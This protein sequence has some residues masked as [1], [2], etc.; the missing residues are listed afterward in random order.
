M[1]NR[2]LFLLELFISM[3]LIGIGIYL[4]GKTFY[5]C[6]NNLYLN[7]TDA[8]PIYTK[9]KYAAECL[10]NMQWPSWFPNWY[11]GTSVSQYY[12][13]L[14][15]IILTPF[16]FFLQNTTLSLKIY[17]F[18]GL[19]IGGMGVW[20]VFHRYFGRFFGILAGILYVT[21]PYFTISFLF[22][23]TIAQVPIIAIAPWYVICCMEY[24]K[25]PKCKTWAAIITLTFIMLLSH[26]MHGFMIAICVF[27]TMLILSV[28]QKKRI[29]NI[30]MWGIGTGLSA[31]ILGFWWV[32]GVLPLENPGVPFLAADAAKD[33]T[34]NLTWF[35]PK[36][37][38]LITSIFPN[39]SNNIDAY[40]P[41]SIILF[42]IVSFIFIKNEKGQRKYILYFL[43]IHT[44]F[45]FIFAFGSY[46]PFYKFIPLANQLVPGRI[47]TQSSIGA[48]VLTAYFISELIRMVFKRTKSQIHIKIFKKAVSLFMLMF[49]ITVTWHSYLYYPKNVVTDYSFEESLYSQ[50]DNETSNFEKGR[51]AWFGDNFNSTNAYFAYMSNYNMVSG[52][53]IEGT[54]TA[55]YLRYQNTALAYEKGDF[56]LKNIYDMNVQ[57]CFVNV[58]N[59]PWLYDLLE[60][61]GFENI[62][63]VESIAI[64]KRKNNSYFM[65]QIRDSIVIGKASNVFLSDNPW[66]V[67]GYSNNPTEYE[68]D[69]LN[70][71]NVVYYCEPEIDN[72][73]QIHMFEE[74]ISQLAESGKSI[75]VEFGRTIFPAPILGVS[76]YSFKLDGEYTIESNDKFNGK[77]FYVNLDGGFIVQLFGIDDALY[78]LKRNKGDFSFDF[79]GTKNIG[80]GKVYFV[81]GPQ[82]QLKGFAFNYLT[83]KTGDNDSLQQRDDL[84]NGIT[85]K[86]FDPLNMYKNLDL[87][88]FNAHEIKWGANN[89]D[90]NYQSDSD[91]RIMS[92][93]TYTPR[94][95]IYIDGMKTKVDR[96]ENMLT[97]NAPAG[98]HHVSM[99]YTMTNFGIIGI[100]VSMLSLIILVVL[101]ILYKKVL[102]LLHSLTKAN[103]I[104]LEFYKPDIEKQV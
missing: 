53:N 102:L 100:L 36:S 16:E 45:A 99:I 76:P 58:S 7:T 65:E 70:N 74:Q 37:E 77:E 41:I 21:L 87:P 48:I 85:Q 61:N 1:K 4:T 55:D 93:I 42:A 62:G 34:A 56:I 2:I 90:F 29:V 44:I 64:M 50:L 40:F 24:Y 71:Y 91:K 66:F 17:I 47:L 78:K 83:G 89:C 92:S 51:L 60:N 43:Y 86:L 103:S 35:F 82:S 95:K 8:M 57:T 26:V 59:F 75:F 88:K 3:L 12:P 104:Y 25:V 27:F 68:I 23:G 63:V 80:N 33:V 69:Y 5:M 15:Y 49:T 94:W 18:F 73:T 30:L 96:V 97:F 39:M 101:L 6:D 31:G 20:S 11:N 54:S 22:W 72:L 28:S 13:P 81:G 52:W 98:K 9:A 67:K 19:F 10:R 46:L 14:T 38:Q 32:T 79:L 84:L